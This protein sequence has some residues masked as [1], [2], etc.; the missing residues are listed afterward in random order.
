MSKSMSIRAIELTRKVFESVYGNLGLLKFSIEELMPT[1]GTEDTE[2]K[3]WDVTCS[4]YETLGSTAPTKYK[5]SVDLKTN[6]I[7]IK[8]LSGSAVKNEE[9]EGAWSVKKKDDKK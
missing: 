9:V 2:S 7:I 5:A 4:F 8:K 3:K 6:T 1:N